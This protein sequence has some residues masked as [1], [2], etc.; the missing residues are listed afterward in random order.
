MFVFPPQASK[1]SGSPLTS[2]KSVDR[3]KHVAL[4][5]PNGNIEGDKTESGGKRGSFRKSLKKAFGRKKGP[6]TAVHEPTPESP[7]KPLK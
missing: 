5:V 3:L 1:R 2:G 6:V 4:I 7:T